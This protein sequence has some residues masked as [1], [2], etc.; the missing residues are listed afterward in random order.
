M[1]IVQELISETA[2]SQGHSETASFVLKIYASN[3]LDAFLSTLLS[4]VP[5][6]SFWEVKVLVTKQSAQA[7][8]AIKNL[9]GAAFQWPHPPPPPPPDPVSRWD[10][11]WARTCR[12][13]E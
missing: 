6:S 10:E 11:S 5:Q 12:V 2:N 3:P 7:R 1:R 13:K 8:T 9:E 4:A